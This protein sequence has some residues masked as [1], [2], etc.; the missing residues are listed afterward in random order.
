MAGSELGA[1]ASYGALAG[2]A[3]KSG[4]QGDGE[5]LCPPLL[6]TSKPHFQ[7]T[8]GVTQGLD[9]PLFSPCD[10]SLLPSLRSLSPS[11]PRSSLSPP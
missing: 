3:G 8:A 7:T 2:K 9:W 11:L 1:R 5:G 10:L 6:N 4:T